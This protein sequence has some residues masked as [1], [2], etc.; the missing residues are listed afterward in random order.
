MIEAPRNIYTRWISSL[1]R[2]PSWGKILVTSA[3]NEGA[4]RFLKEDNQ[5]KIQT[6]LRCALVIC[7]IQCAVTFGQQTAQSQNRQSQTAPSLTDTQR[8]NVLEYIELLRT[9]V[10]GQ[11]DEIMGVLMSLDVD[12]AAKFWPIYGQ[13]DAELTKLNN[14]RARN[15][16]DYARDYYQMT[17]AK[18]DELVQN[19]FNYRR[20]RSDI[21]TRYYGRMKDSLGAVEA[22]RF[23]LIE[24]QLLA[25]IDLQIAS[26]LPGPMVGQPEAAPTERRTQAA[27]TKVTVPAGTRI[28]IRMVNSV[29]SSKQQIGY[30]FTANLETNLQVDDVVVAPRGTTVYGRLAQAKSAGNVSGGAELTLEM[31]DVVINGTAYPLLTSTYQVA[32]Q[33]Q[34]SKT[35]KRVVGGTGL[36]AL[37]GGLAGGGKGAA[38][39]AGAGAAT[40]T[41]ASAATKG[42]QVS[43]PSESLLEFR[44]QHPVSLPIAR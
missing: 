5:M 33:G 27:P 35:A 32:S 1:H 31:T 39:G 23:I 29:D 10:R 7:L 20:Q 3:A 21:L 17:A 40:G 30:R 34:G 15:I 11:K 12:Q 13:Y 41:I 28:L 44:L 18:A 22:A 14:L 9:D 24:D 38:I 43:V 36:G 16:Q 26:A 19:A 2:S 42:K 8:K 25:V 4:V 37:I 6:A